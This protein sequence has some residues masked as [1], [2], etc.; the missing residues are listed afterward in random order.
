MTT[1]EILLIIGAVLLLILPRLVLKKLP[2][3]TQLFVRLSA[4]ILLLVL[5]WGFGFEEANSKWM[6]MFLTII[7]L[8]SIA[9]D[10]KEHFLNKKKT[11]V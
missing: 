7:V 3:K 11:E 5:L 4:A 10:V 1:N 2:N 6:K 8:S 9:K